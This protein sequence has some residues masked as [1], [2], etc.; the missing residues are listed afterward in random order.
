[1]QILFSFFFF[2]PF[3]RINDNPLKLKWDKA[4]QKKKWIKESDEKYGV[5][6]NVISVKINRLE[7]RIIGAKN[8]KKVGSHEMEI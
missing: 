7:G 4:K 2:C 8:K 3:S 1:M 5:M 6:N